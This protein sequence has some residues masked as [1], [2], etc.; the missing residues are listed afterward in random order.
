MS[1]SWGRRDTSWFTEW[2]RPA[3]R[4]SSTTFHWTTDVD[5]RTLSI[6]LT[7]RMLSTDR[8]QVVRRR[9]VV[10]TSRYVQLSD[11]TGANF[12]ILFRRMRSYS[13]EQS[14]LIDIDDRPICRCFF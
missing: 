11:R 2:T 10:A 14:T 12:F 9:C 7:C 3:S 8:D 4:S 6:P 5:T 13:N 1:R